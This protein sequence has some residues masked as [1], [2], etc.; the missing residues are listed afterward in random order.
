MGAAHQDS[1]AARVVKDK[2]RIDALEAQLA[3]GAERERRQA[4]DLTSSRV[5]VEAGN[6]RLEQAD[7]TIASLKTD[8][9]QA[10][11]SKRAAVEAAAELRG[12][13]SAQ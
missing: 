5:A 10:R 11:V 13:A 9:T 4:A 8:L 7:R 6:V 1:L 3:A 2:A 12:A